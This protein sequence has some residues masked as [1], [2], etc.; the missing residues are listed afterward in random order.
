MIVIDTQMMIVSISDS[1]H[2]GIAETEEYLLKP[3]DSLCTAE[4]VFFTQEVLS[5]LKESGRWQGVIKHNNSAETAFEVNAYAI[6]NSADE[7]EYYS[8]FVNYT[9]ARLPSTTQIDLLTKLP[10]QTYLL[11]VLEKRLST[12]Q[13]EL[14]ATSL[15]Y[16]EFDNLT[17]FNETFG[18]DTDDKLIVQLGKKINALLGEDDILARVGNEQFA[19]LSQSYRSEESAK[20]FAK[21]IISLLYEPF[22]IGPNMFYVSAS[23]GINISSSTDRDSYRFL[24]TTENTMRKVQKDGQNHILFTEHKTASTQL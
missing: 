20:V 22:L 7:I 17:R 21:K 10:N 1:K 12:T 2:I 9:D 6:K 8:L 24:K 16:I 19:V 11:S 4:H 13:Q 23:I 14:G 5:T 15:F 3:L 18:F